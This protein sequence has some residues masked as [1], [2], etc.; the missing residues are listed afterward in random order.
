MA[1]L[2]ESSQFEKQCYV[3]GEFADRRE[4]EEG[5]GGVAVCPHIN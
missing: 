1:E 3:K 4:K 2:A 5:G